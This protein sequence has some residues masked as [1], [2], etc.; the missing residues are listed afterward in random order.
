MT[1]FYYLMNLAIN[2]Y[3]MLIILRIWLQAANADYYNPLSQFTVKV[4]QPCLIPLKKII[5]NA[6]RIDFAAVVLALIISFAKYKILYSIQGQGSP[7]AY[8]LTLA[9]LGC[10]KE[11]GT[12]LFWMLIIRAVLSWISRGFNPFETLLAQLT[13]PFMAPIRSKLPDLGGLDL[14]PMLLLVL[15]NFC[16]FL[17]FNL[18][19]RLWSM[20]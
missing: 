1:A 19:G 5:P 12:L 7:L 16:N 9:V 11:V 10:V 6:G 2:T 4:T 14:S 8:Q 17:M 15:L 13:E 20:A 3:L 18:L